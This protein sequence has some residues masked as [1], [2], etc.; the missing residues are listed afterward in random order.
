VLAGSGL[1]EAQAASATRASYQTVQ[2][3]IAHAASPGALRPK[4]EAAARRAAVAASYAIVD[5]GAPPAGTYLS[6]A[7][8][9]FNNTGQIYGIASRKAKELPAV[10]HVDQS[11]LVWTGSKFVDLEPSLTVTG[12]TPYGINSADSA[13]GNYTVVG[14]FTDIHHDAADLPNNG[15]TDAFSAQLSAS[16]VKAVPY[17]DHYPAALYGVNSAAVGVG[18]SA[19]YPAAGGVYY[20]MIVTGPAETMTL[21]EPSCAPQTLECPAPLQRQSRLDG[22]PLAE[23]AFGGCTIDDGGVVL[24]AQSDG[25]SLSS[26][27]ELVSIGSTSKPVLFELPLGNGRISYAVSINNAGRVLYFTENLD[28]AHDPVTAAVYDPGSGKS[29][30]LPPVAG[31][32]CA[33]YFPISM[34]D[35]GQVLGYTSYCSGKAFYWTWDSVNGTRNLSA[36]IPASSFTIEPLGIN[37]E[38]QILVSLATAS[39]TIHWG[40]LQPLKTSS[41]SPRSGFKEV[42]HVR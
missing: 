15:A 4:I 41:S 16:G 38:A 12:C 32:S 6:S 10:G 36:E 42:H 7:P 39:G 14:T 40:T 22:E 2:T 5:V 30:I 37:D 24:T 11:C 20:P 28:A 21:L 31:T 29:T 18:F 19:M 33:H 17:Y 3:G 9:G 23:C 25:T 35:L 26:D 8:I 34:N 13:S 27:L 1:V